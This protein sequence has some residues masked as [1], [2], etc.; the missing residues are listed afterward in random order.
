MRKKT[1]FVSS[2][3]SVVPGPSSFACGLSLQATD[4]G[5]RT[6]DQGQRTSFAFSLHPS[7]FTLHTSFT[8]AIGYQG[9]FVRAGPNPCPGYFRDG[10]GSRTRKTWSARTFFRTCTAPLGHL[11][12]IWP[13]VSA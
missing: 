3:L 12:S 9:P 8:S 13:T 4:K 11:I 5:R 1:S 10:L 6:K 7:Y 2:H